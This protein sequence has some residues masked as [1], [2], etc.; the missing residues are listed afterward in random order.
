MTKAPDRTVPVT[1]LL[2]VYNGG[3]HLEAAVTSILTQT[4]RDLELL[5][6]DDGSTDGSGEWLDT[7]TDPRVR[8]LHQSNEGLVATL[9]QGLGE[10]RYHL[11]ARMDA[12]DVSEPRRLELQVQHLLANPDVAAVGCCYRVIDEC[13]H[14]VDE[15][16]TAADPAYLHRQLYFRNV[17]PHA[18]M[19]FR[20]DVVLEAGGYRDVGPVEDY[21]LWTRLAQKHQI[22]SLPEQLLRYRNSPTGISRQDHERQRT[23]LKAVRGHLH[24]SRPMEAG[25]PRRILRE[26]LQHERR[27][28]PTCPAALRSYIF[29]HAWLAILLGRHGRFREA[30]QL[31][32]GVVALA[33][34]RPTAAG[35]LV[36]VARRR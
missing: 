14:V 25:G 17:L 10:A 34:R 23:S 4:H 19:T 26:G 5:V 1:V 16:H 31:M 36:D 13:D 20:R 18:G 7:L 30:A 35:G 8:V 3:R 33:L 28:G 27:Y 24:A 11:V 21:D 6:I 2:P 22:S 29:D 9:N 12:D 15:V 32:A